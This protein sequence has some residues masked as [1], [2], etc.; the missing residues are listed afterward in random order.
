M[1]RD[2]STGFTGSRALLLIV[3]LGLAACSGPNSDD[4]GHALD[5]TRARAS[6]STV[7]NVIDR[8][9]CFADQAEAAGTVAPCDA[10]SS[11]G[12]RLQ[13]YAV[14][15]ERAEAVEP[16]HR[17]PTDSKTGRDLRDACISGVAKATKRPDLC[18]EIVSFGLRDSCWLGIFQKTGDPA[19]CNRIEDAGLRTICKGQPVYVE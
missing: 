18:E 15:A 2:A 10:A 5:S 3:G 13:C 14:Y 16:C 12:V 6:C 4:S 8:I 19:L 9:L 17:I 11:E 1:I 7:D